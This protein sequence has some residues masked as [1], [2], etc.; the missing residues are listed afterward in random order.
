VLQSALIDAEAFETATYNRTLTKNDANET[1]M[2]INVREGSTAAVLRQ[3]IA[4][5]ISE[6]TGAHIEPSRVTLLLGDGEICY[7]EEVRA[8]DRDSIQAKLDIHNEDWRRVVQKWS[9]PSL[10]D[11]IYQLSLRKSDTRGVWA[12]V[13]EFT[14]LVMCINSLLR[15]E[16]RCGGSCDAADDE[17]TEILEVLQEASSLPSSQ[18]DSILNTFQDEFG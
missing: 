16:Q 3:Q 13:G 2:E 6:T 12:N 4:Q 7:T 17:V 14:S 8:I 10:E 9:H 15:R 11:F 18:P 1:N 5:R